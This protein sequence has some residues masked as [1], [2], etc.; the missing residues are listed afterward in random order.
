MI[1]DC[2]IS[3]KTLPKW[4]TF[5]QQN[6][7]HIIFT[8]NELLEEASFDHIIEVIHKEA[9]LQLIV[10]KENGELC[11]QIFSFQ[12][13]LVY[14]SD[15]TDSLSPSDCVLYSGGAMGAENFFGETAGKFG[16]REINFTFEGHDQRRTV[17]STLLSDK[18]LSLGSTSLNYVSRKLRRNWDHTPSIQKIL[19][20]LWHVVSHAEQVFV[21]GVIQPDNTVHGGTGWSV[22][23]AKRWHK[24]IW[25]YD[26]DQEAWFHWSGSQWE[27]NLPTISSKAFAGSGTRF[28]SEPAKQAIQDLFARSFE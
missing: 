26:Q 23:L 20:V 17:G 12:R 16:C 11:D 8:Q 18:E 19:Q 9:E 3:K 5:A 28:L 22:E 25:V 27:K 10:R 13:N 24:P 7:L 4:R 15:K 1:D 14:K 6:K 21:V 2:Q